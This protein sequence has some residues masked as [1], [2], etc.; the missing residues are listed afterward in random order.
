MKRPLIQV[1]TP[2]WPY[3]F[4][5]ARRCAVLLSVYGEM[6]AGSWREFRLPKSAAE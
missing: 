4:C 6:E 3:R 5:M 1:E 2:C